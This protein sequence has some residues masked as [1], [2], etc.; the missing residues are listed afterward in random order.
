MANKFSEDTRIRTKQM[1]TILF[2]AGGLM[3]VAGQLAMAGPVGTAF[4]YQGQLY[5]TSYPANGKYDF[6]FKLYDASTEGNKVGTD[7]NVP[8]VNV[9]DGYFPVEIDFGSGV[10]DGNARWLEIGVRPGD[11]DDP[12]V[13]TVLSPRQEIKPAPYALYA[14]SGTAGPQ[15]EQSPTEPI[16][17]I[18]F[19]E[20]TTIKAKNGTTGQIEFSGTDARTVIQAAINTLTSGTVLV[21]D[22]T[23]TLNGSGTLLRI[24]SN[25][26]LKGESREGT[27]LK[28]A[29]GCIAT[30]YIA[31]SGNYVQVRDLTLDGN[32]GNNV[33]QNIES[34]QCGIL[35]W[36]ISSTAKYVVIDNVYVHDTYS[37]GIYIIYNSDYL[38][39]TNSRIENTNDSSIQASYIG[40]G[41]I[42]NNLC[43]GTDAG[44]GV[45]IQIAEG[46]SVTGNRF[47]NCYE[48]L[49][50]IT[51]TNNAITGNVIKSTTQIGVYLGKSHKNTV[52]GN[53]VDGGCAEAG[54]YIADSNSNSIVGN[55]ICDMLGYGL[56]LITSQYNVIA[57]NIFDTMNIH[58]MGIRGSS[59]NS[60]NGNVIKDAGILTDNTYHGMI[61]FTSGSYYSIHNNIINNYIVSFAPNKTRS[62]IRENDTNQDYQIIR[63]NKMVGMAYADAIIQGANT[64]ARYNIGYTTESSGTATITAGQ[65]SVNVTHNL[66]GAPTRVQLTPTTDTAGKR[67]WVSAKGS[68]TF[69]I[70][71]DSAY[72]SDISFD[73]N[74]VVGEDN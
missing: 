70:S 10:F 55:T 42:A 18:I 65:T 22:G 2:L 71:I 56:Q 17:Y 14:K 21:R 11:S 28:V 49:R 69:T 12:N 53:T 32:R 35:V 74:A 19:I 20:G 43:K 47:E 26:T 59:Y 61:L 40:K 1:L 48:G 45:E 54:F 25:I 23:Y 37:I 36:N 72:A 29:D 16:S 60:I 39:V 51:A 52:S 38:R 68:S 8:E 31:V 58:G 50:I 27:I 6:A 33:D 24:P 15:G 62:G 73:W 57:E 44:A 63:N 4:T 3:L 67:Y 13:Y 5:D 41:V 9:V 34:Q 7:V 46:T 30:K 66:A 64:K